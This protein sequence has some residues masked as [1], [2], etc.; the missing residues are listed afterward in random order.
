M[1]NEQMHN[2]EIREATLND[3][4]AIRHMHAQSW[5][6]TYPNDA[7]GITHEWVRE[8]TD[9]WLTPTALERSRTYFNEVFSTNEHFYRVVVENGSVVGLVHAHTENGH[10]HLGALY[11]LRNQQGTGLAQKLME[12]VDLWVGEEYIDLEVAS[13]NTRAIRFYEKYGFRAT[14][15]RH[16]LFKGKIPI[17]TMERTGEKA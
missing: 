1:E 10:K 5:I 15:K 11:L 13:Y 9:K 2:Y 12:L 16:E 7:E 4:E 17:V 3:V 8:E 14:D 6:E